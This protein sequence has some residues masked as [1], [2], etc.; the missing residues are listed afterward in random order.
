M[1]VL[2]TINGVW[3]SSGGPSTCTYNLMEAISTLGDTTLLCA[4]A[5]EGD[6][7]CGPAKPWMQMVGN[8][9]RLGN[10]AY[11]RNLCDYL[12]RTTY[13][14]YHTHGNWS[15]YNHYTARCARRKHKPYIISPHGN[16]YPQA[17]AIS[18]WKKRLMRQ[19]WVDRDLRGAAA[20]CTTSKQEMNY[21][22]DLGFKNPI[23]VIANPITIPEY[24]PEISLQKSEK[25]VFGFLGRL[26]P[27]KNIDKILLAWASLGEQVKGAELHIYGRGEKTYE[28]FLHAEAQRLKLGNVFFKETVSGRDKYE[29]LA[30]MTAL[31]SPSVQENFGM[32]IAEGLL[33]STPTLASLNTPWE[34]LESHRCGW[35]RTN[36]VQT[37]AATIRE[38]LTLSPSEMTEMGLRGRKLILEKYSAPIIARQ[39][40]ALY[41][42]ICRGQKTDKPDF[43]YL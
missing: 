6:R 29:A 42:W 12:D 8:D 4:E 17:L 21:I 31:L 23:A 28:S 9:L 1:K 33:M 36:D 20:I 34:E 18:K 13:D 39:M 22:R 11:S 35:W 30:G 43:I 26:H 15:H 19:I 32:S 5:P 25:P 10:F 24:L 14:I 38:A 2:Q 3:A 27:I 41:D 7:L 37:I 40:L 16:L